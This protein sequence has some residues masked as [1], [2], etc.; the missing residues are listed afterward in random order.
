VCGA[1]GKAFRS[2]SALD[3]HQRDTGHC[4]E[5]FVCGVCSKTFSSDAALEQHQPYTGHREEEIVCGVC[6]KA[7][8][9]DAALEQ[10]QRDTD[11][12]E[13]E[14]VCGV[15]GKALRSE[16]AL[17][18]HQRDT[19]HG[20]G[21]DEQDAQQGASIASRPCCRAQASGAVARKCPHGRGCPCHRCSYMAAN[22]LDREVG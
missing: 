16:A 10:H 11:H 20:F 22:P 12:C 4:E 13:E 1:C 21:Y 17:E 6:G 9:G 15:R 3:Q 8:S 7:F 14:F 2:E 19:G 5:E 18:Q